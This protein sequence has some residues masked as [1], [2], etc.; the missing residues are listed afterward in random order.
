MAAIKSRGCV[1]LQ[2]D[3]THAKAKVLQF[4]N[5]FR[6]YRQREPRRN[7]PSSIIIIILPQVEALYI[8]MPPQVTTRAPSHPT[9]S[10]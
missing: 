5:H 8:V 6:Q 7:A 1:R 4:Y 3:A 2:T 9:S 10:V